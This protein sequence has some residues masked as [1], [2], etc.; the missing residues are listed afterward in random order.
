[1]VSSMG[2]EVVPAVNDIEVHI[3]HS[4][5]FQALVDLMHD[6][7]AGKSALVGAIRR[8]EEDLGGNGDF[9][10]LRILLQGMAQVSLRIPVRLDIGRV[11]EVDS[12]VKGGFDHLL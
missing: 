4:Q 12:Q 2:G 8:S 11:E 3:V 1:M 9:I 7:L 6:R 10:P 5:T